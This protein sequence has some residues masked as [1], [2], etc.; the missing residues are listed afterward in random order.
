MKVI[1][2]MIR[3]ALNVCKNVLIKLNSIIR[4]IVVKE[5]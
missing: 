1:D 4:L 5:W 2:L 3:R